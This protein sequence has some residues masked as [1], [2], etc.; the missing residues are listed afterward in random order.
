[1]RPIHSDASGVATRTARGHM[2]TSVVLALAATA[3]MTLVSIAPAMATGGSLDR[4]SYVVALWQ[5]PATGDWP[6]SLVTSVAID[7]PSL[8]DGLA[9]I[10]LAKLQCG[11][12]F[13]ADL[14]HSDSTTDALL[15]GKVLNGP[16]NPAESWPG[17][18]WNKGKSYYTSGS[19]KSEYTS[20]PA[21]DACPT[22]DY[23][24][25]V[26]PKIIGCGEDTQFQIGDQIGRN[27]ETPDGSYASDFAQ[28]AADQTP[29]INIFFTPATGK[30]INPDIWDHAFSAY[31]GWWYNG[32]KLQVTFKV[33]ACETTP[34][35]YVNP[36]TP[37]IV[38]CSANTTLKVHDTT[39]APGG[40]LSA[41]GGS[42]YLSPTPPE[43]EQVLFFNADEDKTIKDG[44]YPDAAPLVGTDAFYGQ[45]LLGD[46]GL[47]Y[48]VRES[49]CTEPTQEP[50]TTPTQ[51]PTTTPTQPAA[52]VPTTTTTPVAASHHVTSPVVGAP[53]TG[54]DSPAPI[55]WILVLSTIALAAITTL[56]T[57]TLR[58]RFVQ[59]FR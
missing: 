48:S 53:S 54:N 38:G 14:Y 28:D 29:V 40:T 35:E 41:D 50:T 31:G 10:N 18:F 21:T 52:P 19:W 3:A 6:Q 13:Q 1:M 25:P 44:Q 59:L 33:K 56:S 23:V 43:G 34:P 37:T 36:V 46:N 17:G 47:Q 15:N 32:T 9:K 12:S 22:P 45:W 49:A 26:A 8:S 27:I 7:Q 30:E 4:D 58:R 57:P 55:G 24:I 16:N 11:T 2:R 5:K 39:L 51:E 42:Y 20:Y